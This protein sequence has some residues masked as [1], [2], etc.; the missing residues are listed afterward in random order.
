VNR[1]LCSVY[2]IFMLERVKRKGSVH[3]T[4]IAALS[5]NHCGRRKVLSVKYFDYVSVHLL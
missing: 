4:N 3:I 5:L 1:T 2:V